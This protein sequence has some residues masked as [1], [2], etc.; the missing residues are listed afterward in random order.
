MIKYEIEGETNLPFQLT[1]L[2]V[3]STADGI[4]DGTNQLEIVQSNDLYFTIEKNQN[5]NGKQMIKKV[6]IENIEILSRPL[7]GKVVL[8]RPSSQGQIVYQYQEDYI[9]KDNICYDADIETNLKTLSI[10]NQG[11]TIGFRTSVKGITTYQ[12][13]D[14]TTTSLINDSALLQKTQVSINDIKYN[15]G[16]DI[17]IELAD[18]K[19]YKGYVNT[20]LPMGDLENQRVS[21]VEKVNIEKVIFKRVKF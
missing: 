19:R 17:V 21:A 6:S 14:G 11:G 20:T 8:Y 12:A 18:G 2:M 15:I 5:Y 1:N 9:I 3:I 4:S 13:E 7:K 10:S 16:F